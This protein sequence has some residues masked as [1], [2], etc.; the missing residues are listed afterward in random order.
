MEMICKLCQQEKPLLRRSHIIPDFMYQGIFDEDHFLYRGNASNLEN[1]DMVPTGEYEGNILCREC[2][3]EV[4]GRYENYSSC[5]LYGGRLPADECPTFDN[6]HIN[7]I[8]AILCRNFEYHKFKLFLL[9]I[10]WRSS[11]SNRDFFRNVDLGSNEEN[12]RAMII[13]GDAGNDTNYPI[14]IVSFLG[15]QNIPSEIIGQPHR[16]RKDQLEGYTYLINGFFYI[17]FISSEDLPQFYINASINHS[18]EMKII[19]LQ[20]EQAERFLRRYMGY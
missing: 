5:A 17:F 18:N 3:N 19:Q 10:L 20:P 9:S 13:N 1:V 11:I 2:D 7:D 16:F 6:I 12:I 15:N 14:L 8:Q 4:I